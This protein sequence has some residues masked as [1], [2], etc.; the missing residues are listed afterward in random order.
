[1]ELYGSSGLQKGSDNKLVS[2]WGEIWGYCRVSTKDQ[3]TD[4]QE[5]AMITY[6]VDP[7]HI[8]IEHES[9]KNFNRPMYKRLIRIVRKG[10]II[11][12]KSIDRLGRNYQDIID[13][14]RMI[15]Q[16]IGCGIHVLD[17]PTLNTSGDPSD[18][19]SK[20]ITD[21]MLYSASIITGNLRINTY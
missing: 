19:L 1:M 14:W 13:Q 18:L 16:D 10:D 21:M 20:F 5:D 8:F 15:T 7:K 2:P 3:N 11:V 9:G 6:G 17:M 4:R 12:I